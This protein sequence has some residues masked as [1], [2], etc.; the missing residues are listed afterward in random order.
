MSAQLQFDFE[1]AEFIYY[2]KKIKIG[3]G[4]GV[5]KYFVWIVCI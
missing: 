4:T 3:T 2:F 5:L 1:V